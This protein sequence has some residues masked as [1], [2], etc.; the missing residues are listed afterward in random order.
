MAKKRSAGV[1]VMTEFPGMGLVA[2]LQRRGEFN[3]EKMGP[4]SYP[5]GCQLTAHGG[6]EDSEAPFDTIFREALEEMGAP[7]GVAVGAA[8][9]GSLVNAPRLNYINTD[10]KEVYSYGQKM[11][12][13][14]LKSIK[15][16]PSSGGV[17]L[18]TKERASKIRNLK[19][20]TREEGVDQLSIIAMFLDDKVAVLKA[21]KYFAS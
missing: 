16:G 10:E 18:V 20:F 13:D 15:L 4:E 9:S 7:F 19:E 5:G 14:F 17:V 2:V 6:M 1:L 21:F 12:P 3:H 11:N 8:L